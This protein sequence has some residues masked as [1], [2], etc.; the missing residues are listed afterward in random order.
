MPDIYKPNFHQIGRRE[1][2]SNDTINAMVQDHL[3]FVWIGSDNGLSRY[4][5]HRMHTYQT[6]V[7]DGNSIN[8]NVITHL[9]VDKENKIWISTNKILDFYE[10]DKNYFIHIIDKKSKFDGLSITAIHDI[11]EDFDGHL[12]V[13]SNIGLLKFNL[14]GKLVSFYK[15]NT[16]KLPISRPIRIFIINK[17]LFVSD[18]QKGLYK[19][20]D[21]SHGFEKFTKDING[22]N[23]ETAN[24]KDLVKIDEDLLWATTS[25]GLLQLNSK[26]KVIKILSKEKVNGLDSNRFLNVLPLKDDLLAVTTIDNGLYVFYA[27][28]EIKQ[29]ILYENSNQYSL[30]SNYIN[31]LMNDK[32]ENLWVATRDNGVG[33]WKRKNNFIS[34]I[35]FEKNNSD[36]LLDHIVW[37]VRQDENRRFYV[38]TDTG[39]SIWDDKNNKFDH[40]IFGKTK[41]G[42]YVE[43][44][45]ISEPIDDKVWLAT[46]IGLKSINIISKEII[47]IRNEIPFL[48][49]FNDKPIYNVFNDSRKRLWVVHKT[50]VSLV[51]LQDKTIRNFTHIDNDN[52]SLADNQASALTEDENGT[53][54]IGTSRGICSYNEQH[55]DFNCFLTAEGDFT[56][57]GSYLINGLIVKDNI[58]WVGYSGNGLI[59]LDLSKPESPQHYNTTS[60]FPTNNVAGLLMDEKERLWISSQTGLI[61]FNPKNGQIINLKGRDG[62]GDSEFNEGA[63]TTLNDGRFAF[64][65]IKGVVIVDPEKFEFNKTKPSVK[66]SGAYALTDNKLYSMGDHFE[67]PENNSGLVLTF[68]IQDYF[69]PEQARYQYRLGKSKPWI[70]LKNKSE[71]SFD[72]FSWGEHTIQVR[73]KY[74]GGE[75]GPVNSISFYTYPP[76]WRSSFALLIYALAALS[77]I[78]GFLYYRYLRNK[79][80]YR[81]LEVIK[82]NEQQLRLSLDASQQGV[83]DW[84]INNDQ[85]QR[86]KTNELLHIL[87]PDTLVDYW[88]LIEDRDRLSV[89]NAW[90]GH[91]FG[92]TK[93]YYCQYRMKVEGEEEIWIEEQGRAIERDESSM[94]THITGTYRN[95]TEA[96]LLEKKLNLLA[97]AFED[98]AEGVLIVDSDLN[99]V[100]VNNA[101][102]NITG[103]AE[104]NLIGKSIRPTTFEKMPLTFYDE[105]WQQV[106]EKGLWQGEVWQTNADGDDIPLW[107][108]VS[109]IQYEREQETFYVLIIS[110]I[111]ERKETEEELRYLANY[112]TLT[113]LPNRALLRDRLD[114]GLNNAK[115]QNR[116]IA[117]LFLDLDRFKHVNDSFGHSVGDGLLVAVSERLQSCLRDDDTVSRIGGDEFVILMEHFSSINAIAGVTEKIRKAMSSPFN[118][119]GVDIQASFS[120]GVSV[121]PGDGEDSATLL[122]NADTAMYH[123][124]SA[125]RNRVQFYAPKMNETALERLTLEN[126]LRS[127]IGSGQLEV[128]YQP[129]ICDKDNTFYG[130]E[131]LVRWNHPEKGL[132]APINFIPMAEESDLIVS[133]GNEVLYKACIQMKKWQTTYGLNMNVSINLAARQLLQIDLAQHIENVVKRAQLSPECV[134]L[135]ITETAVMEDLDRSRKILNTLREKGF[136][137]A[138]D[139]FGTGYSSLNYLRNIPLDILK[140]DYTFVRDLLDNSVDQA[141]VSAIIEIGEALDL[142]VLAEGIEQE[143]QR[144]FLSNKGCQYFQGYFFG[145]PM[146]AIEFEKILSETTPKPKIK[147]A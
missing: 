35:D 10:Y 91:L 34:R 68:S 126:D 53:I 92:H 51:N 40:Y 15:I 133:L 60:D 6:S 129:Q 109:D 116:P 82:E 118:L 13:S 50:G 48:K 117:I 110:D 2:L 115:R 18:F 79:E 135:E 80:K 46:G 70:D 122:R 72:G 78:V 67:M 137:I 30:P 23:P 62:T 17:Q 56:V 65:T 73:G 123:A 76:S 87:T 5:G 88:A 58:L 136:K 37:S 142:Q 22:I 39:L 63:F 128:Y 141:I 107:L 74:L 100:Q 139:D 33:V 147:N 97:K 3:G 93:N 90:N 1:G 121:F 29:H 106:A 45:A 64:G 140:I 66:F 125:G 111:R 131:A 98:T 12:W 52:R 124:K 95:I 114:H 132:I 89:I 103:Y 26:G 47:D 54:W 81:M 16:K 86:S 21:E 42:S 9:E 41:S 119:E 102:T 99:I 4:D 57:S 69:H 55:Y 144:T 130:V 145:K 83:W 77:L 94:A 14:Q 105:I 28:G 61:V 134:C 7:D 127:A 25:N 113:R 104:N 19:F 108:N 112:D 27:N 84:R 20:N 36:G 75:W 96:K 43:V 24:I 120:V 101:V 8:G 146:P 71:I 44:S 59:R 49:Q 138:I 31:N 11:K 143:E 85:M 32:N 38:G